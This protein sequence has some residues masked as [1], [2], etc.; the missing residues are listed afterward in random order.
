[1]TEQEIIDG[2]VILA[3]IMG[4]HYR[5]KYGFG[6]QMGYEFTNDPYAQLDKHNTA[7]WYS[8]KALKF[9]SSWDWLMPIVENIEK[10]NYGIKQC[11]KV[12]EI[13]FDDTKEVII[14]VK[15]KSR[16]ESLWKAIIE[17]YNWYIKHVAETSGKEIYTES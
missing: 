17:F 10:G 2:N 14:K 15:E 7:S 5:H 13:Y 12:V 6:D 9:H 3:K 8:P 4:G 11:R 1:M 16:I